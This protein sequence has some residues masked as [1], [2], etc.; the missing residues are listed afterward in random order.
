[1]PTL[2]A[3]PISH[4]FINDLPVLMHLLHQTLGLGEASD[5]ERPRHENWQRRSQ[6][7]V[8]VTRL[9]HI[10]REHNRFMSHVQEWVKSVP[11]TL[12]GLWGSVT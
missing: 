8:M 4:E 6:G 7:Q 11:Q 12:A 2:T 9:V 1:M 5:Q 3:C 10:L